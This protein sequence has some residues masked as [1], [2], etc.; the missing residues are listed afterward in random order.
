M[1]LAILLPCILLAQ[2]P[3]PGPFQEHA[4]PFVVQHH[5]TPAKHLIETM[6][7]GV[8]VFDYNGDGRPDVFFTNG[9]AVPSLTKA[10][11]ADQNRLYRNDGNFRFTD[12]TATAGLAGSGY[13]MGA[14]A[15]DF[16]NDGHVD[17]F[18]TGVF[19][20]AL[21]RNRG[22]GT[23]EDI[24]A[25]SGLTNTSL[26]SVAAG[27]FDYDND[28]QL[29]L[30]VVNYAAWSPSFDKFCGDVARGIRVYCHPRFFGELPNQI[31]R[32]LGGGRFQDV[33]RE[34]GIAA[35]KGRGMSVAFADYDGD[36]WVDV[37]VPNDK[38]PNSLFRNLGGKRFEETAL[39]AGVA[40]PLDGKSISGMGA[41]FQDYD[42]DGRP[43]LFIT[44]L[45]GETF[46]LFRNTGKGE[47]QDATFVTKLASLSAKYSG[48]SNGFAD[49]DNDGWK[50]LWSANSH[51]N[52][53]IN[54]FEPAS[55]YRQPNTLFL[56]RS[57]GKTFQVQPFGSA[58]AHRG[59]AVADFD[60]DGRLD[61]VVSVL[62]DKAEVWQNT[63][64]TTG[65]HWLG[66]QL[67][68]VTSNRDGIGAVVRVNGQTLILTTSA[69]Y[70][71]SS[72]TPLHFGLGPATSATVEIRWPSGK[73]QKLPA[74]KVD[75]ILSVTEP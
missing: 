22:D 52:D 72:H 35:H 8:A 32:N 60:G 4:L 58:K 45:N 9:A 1:R 6:P 57:S 56:S 44:A 15:A 42:N 54:D 30:L 62:G 65:A 33:S 69:G 75:Q 59:G 74:P 28:G 37:F 51:V 53:R 19:H 20:N 27:W 63:F 31:F 21:Y 70:A 71:S 16:D 12:V 39:L 18:V 46:P 34:T 2:A 73:L 43:D 61:I 47:F 36:G 40:L 66:I 10:G 41:D 5:P 50:D 55:Q 29:D 38:L 14:A 13:A 67:R 49:F 25:K 17:L 48:W 26:W 3:S 7:G 23:F 11:E 68:G 64:P 24:T